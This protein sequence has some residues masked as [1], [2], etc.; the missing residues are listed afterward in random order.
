MNNDNQITGMAGEFLAMGKLSKKRLQVTFTVGNAKS[1][2]IFAH[3]PNTEKTYTVQVK[4]SRKKNNFRDVKI[5]DIKNVDVFIFI[6]LNDDDFDKNEDYFIVK[7]SEIQKD[8]Q[9]FFGTTFNNKNPPEKG[10]VNYRAL[11]EYKNKWKVFDQ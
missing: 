10:T 2:D 5:K 7:S 1:I 6:I 4:T 8:M 11:E 3:N 9:K